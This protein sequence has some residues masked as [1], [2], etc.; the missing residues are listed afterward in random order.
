M[1]WFKSL[2]RKVQLNYS[3][4]SKLFDVLGNKIALKDI[5]EK[6]KNWIWSSSKYCMINFLNLISTLY[7]R[8][9]LVLRRYLLKYL[10]IKE[11]EVCNLLSNEPEKENYT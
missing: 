4:Q 8:A 2:I 10:G 11:Q 1:I 6:I 3:M 7:L 9:Q 5:I